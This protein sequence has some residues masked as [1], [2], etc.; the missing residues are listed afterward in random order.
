VAAASDEKV[1]RLDIAMNNS[2]GVR[3]IQRVRNFDGDIEQ[4]VYFQRTPVDQVLQRRTVQIFHGDER[5]AILL[6]NVVDGANAGWFSA[7]AACA[8]R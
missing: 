6:A 2:L 8:S 3:R 1:S 5:P 7:D 4:S